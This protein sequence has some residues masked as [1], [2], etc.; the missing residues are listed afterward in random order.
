MENKKIYLIAV[1]VVVGVF[2]SSIVIGGMM[3]AYALEE[4]TFVRKW[5]SYGAVAGKFSQPIEIAIDSKGYLYVTDFTGV[6]HENGC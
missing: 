1:V 6:T 5:G 2:L 4:Y 3:S